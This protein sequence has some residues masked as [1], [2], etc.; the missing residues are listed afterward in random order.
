MI[1]RL[2]HALF[3]LLTSAALAPAF[4]AV[5]YIPYYRIEPSR[6]AENSLE[7]PSWD[8]VPGAWDG[9]IVSDLQ[10]SLPERWDDASWRLRLARDYDEFCLHIPF[11][12]SFVVG[13]T[14]IPANLGWLRELKASDPDSLIRLSLI[15]HSSDFLPITADEKS[16]KEFS[17]WLTGLCV[18]EGLDGIDIDWE[19]SA[20]PREMENEAITALAA[21]LQ[22]DLPEQMILSAAVSRW[23]LPDKAFFR[24]LDAVHLMAYDGYGR[25]STMESALADSEIVRARMELQEGQLV[26][27]IPFY[28][29]IFDDSDENYFHG[30]MNY[31]EILQTY[32]PPMSADEAG[33]YFFNGVDT[34]AAKARWAQKSGLRGVFS[35]E[36]FYDGVGDRSLSA[37]IREVATLPPPVD[38]E[39]TE[40]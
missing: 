32:N 10:L 18:S 9:R 13:D 36:P 28:G 37:V 5:T 40:E 19:F 6:G 26:L 14:L 35:W 17:A 21:A 2:I 22:E 27:G 25:H 31:R 11:D 8:T 30:T 29:R 38:S 20:A 3:F 15:G 12:E 16:L 1:R 33:G 7:R 24:E 39:D 4:Q 23:R 34:V